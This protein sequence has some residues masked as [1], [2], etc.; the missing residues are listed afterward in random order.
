MKLVYVLYRIRKKTIWSVHE[1]IRRHRE[2]SPRPMAEFMQDHY[3]FDGGLV[4]AELGVEYGIHAL[5]MLRYLNIKKLYLVDI[6]KTPELVERLREYSDKIEFVNMD[7][8]KATSIVPDGLDFVYVDA[9][10][11]YESASDDINNW[12]P[13]VRIGGVF[14][15][16]DIGIH[17]V[18]K[19][20]VEFMH[21]KD[22]C[23]IDYPDWWVVK[24]G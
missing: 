21:D 7:T 17:S 3:G 19:A 6:V 2:I 16:H 15:G 5:S 9:D 11:S 18:I 22:E 8:T 20:V 13:K 14:G 10:H 4:G 12:Y 23:F 24:E 1:Y